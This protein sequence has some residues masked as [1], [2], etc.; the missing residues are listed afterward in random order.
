MV[1]ETKIVFEIGDIRGL[2]L[3]C[4][5]C[6]NETMLLLQ[7]DLPMPDV[8]NVCHQAWQW[9]GNQRNTIKDAIDKLRLALRAQGSPVRLRFEIDA[10]PEMTNPGS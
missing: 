1:K 10:D 7:C 2:R 4:V 3:V 6:K 5:N 9:P 8:C